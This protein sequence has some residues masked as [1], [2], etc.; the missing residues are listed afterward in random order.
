MHVVE[1]VMKLRDARRHLQWGHRPGMQ[2]VGGA[3][4]PI[5]TVCRAGGPSQPAAGGTGRGGFAR[6]D[7]RAPVQWGWKVLDR[8]TINEGSWNH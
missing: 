4:Q 5:T 1:E 2:S 3:R 7:L 6:A 8:G